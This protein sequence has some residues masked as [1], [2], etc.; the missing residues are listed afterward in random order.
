[1]EHNLTHELELRSSDEAL[2]LLGQNGEL[3]RLIQTELPVRIVDR[4][5]TVAIIGE[6][7]DAAMV[8]NVLR[9]ML[10]AVRGAT[11]RP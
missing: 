11:R 5:G 4:G 6:E 9:E 2:K 7:A 3:R 8:H 10:V 1:M